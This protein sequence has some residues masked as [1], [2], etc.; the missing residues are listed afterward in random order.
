MIIYAFF[1]T[2]LDVRLDEFHGSFFLKWGHQIRHC[3]GQL[4]ER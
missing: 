3:Y 1:L 4:V 2:N